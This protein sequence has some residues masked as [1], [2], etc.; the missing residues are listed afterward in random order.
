MDKSKIKVIALDLDGTLTQHKQPL[1]PEARATLTALSEKYKLLMVGAGQVQRIFNQMEHFPVDIIG[2]YGLQYATYNAETDAMEMQRDL[3]L[4]TSD[5]ESVEA[6]VTALREKHG[7]TEFAGDNVEYHPSGCLTFP[8]L[9]TKAQQADK[10]A[11]DPDRVKR[12][13]IYAEVCENFPDYCVFVGGSS[14]FDMA[15]KPYNKYHALDLYCRENGL[16]HDNVLFIGD[17]YGVGGNDE[18]VYV[19]DIPFLCVD[20]YTQFPRL[21]QFLLAEE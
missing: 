18:S 19:S 12:R 7:F 14:S 16:E 21:V 1:S 11:F 20:D 8:I 10:L 9:G 3:V 17:D 13:K 15:P 2:N 4:P 5:R 6:K